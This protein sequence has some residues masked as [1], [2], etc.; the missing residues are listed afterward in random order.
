MQAYRCI[1]NFGYERKLVEGQIY[2]GTEMP[3]TFA[4]S[5]YLVV[6]D[7]NGIELAVAHLRRF[8]KVQT[9]D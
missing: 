2:L 7:G 9:D 3:G 6:Y 1:A 5:P 8:E 4:D